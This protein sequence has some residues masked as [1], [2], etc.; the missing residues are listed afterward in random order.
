MNYISL[1]DNPY[2]VYENGL[3]EP[4]L[5]S[6]D[7]ASF[8]VIAESLFV[9]TNQTNHSPQQ[10]DDPRRMQIAKSLLTIQKNERDGAYVCPLYINGDDF[11]LKQASNGIDLIV[12]ATGKTPAETTTLRHISMP[13][14]RKNAL[15]YYLETQRSHGN[16][17]IHL[18][19][20]N[21]NDIDLSEVNLA[22]TVLNQENL[23]AVIASKGDLSGATLAKEI[24]VKDLAFA[25]I[26][27]DKSILALLIRGKANLQ[28]INV[29]GKDLS[30]MSLMN[31]N[32][33][34]GNFTG[35]N[36]DGADLSCSN[37]TGAIFDRTTMENA[38]TELALF[39]S[40]D[41]NL[42]RLG[43]HNGVFKRINYA[44]LAPMM[45]GPDFNIYN[46][47]SKCWEKPESNLI[48]IENNEILPDE[49]AP[50]SNP[51]QHPLPSKT[52][53]SHAISS[54]F[55]SPENFLS[56][57]YNQVINFLST[58]Q[59]ESLR[60]VGIGKNGLPN[61]VRLV[62]YTPIDIDKVS[63]YVKISG[64]YKFPPTSLNCTVPFEGNSDNIPVPI[65]NEEY[66]GFIVCRH[67]AA[68]F[69]KDTLSNPNGKVDFRKFSTPK[70]LA[71]HV[72]PE[73]EQTDKYVHSRAK[74]IQLIDN[75]Q[76]GVFLAK[77]FVQM[78]KENIS[79]R[80]M[81]IDSHGHSMAAGLH[82]K[83]YQDGS[84]NYSVQ[85]M[86]PNVGE[87]SPVH[88]KVSNP[89]ELTGQ[90]LVDYICGTNA[91]DKS[92][93]NHYYAQGNEFSRVFIHDDPILSGSTPPENIQIL[94]EK[95][96]VSPSHI[97]F[98]MRYNTAFDHADYVNKLQNLGQD[99]LYKVLS[100]TNSGYGWLPIELAVKYGHVDA[101]KEYGELLKLIDDKKMRAKLLCADQSGLLNNLGLMPALS[102]G[103]WKAIFVY[104]K[105][106]NALL[107]E[108]KSDSAKKRD[109]QPVTR[110][111]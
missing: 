81:A 44:Q 109:G 59:V 8:Q 10:S 36:L 42:D 92:R 17:A 11:T 77:Q 20:F 53:L 15:N 89:R 78:E 68:Q 47:D 105:I 75:N 86:D 12:S 96:S 110:K 40:F 1:Y 38:K 74:Q 62:G 76:F 99:E 33:S 7:A 82:I 39:E 106:V 93:Y 84:K 87:A 88:S 66:K 32:F 55:I 94:N 5:F 100:G 52:T 21:V 98:M 34:G 64:P 37:F 30:G 14:L 50:G 79:V 41:E 95:T 28:G 23:K 60:L 48:A 57:L 49:P 9:L 56:A 45:K 90:R 31:V 97:T 35:A 6:G 24:N 91:T 26:R 65:G 69:I 51:A 71:S 72:K 18:S 73:A 46:P 13:E 19:R 80:A 58:K 54:L 103:H 102:S 70:E 63:P 104:Y 43:V 3:A 85:Y 27:M 83:S 61:P 67:T 16:K 111:E 107:D 25:E 4:Q 22:D 2:N 101:I 108:R 29:C